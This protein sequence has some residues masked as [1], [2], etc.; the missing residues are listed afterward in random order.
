MV[1]EGK[2]RENLLLGEKAGEGRIEEKF[3]GGEV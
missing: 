3:I 1:L 2:V